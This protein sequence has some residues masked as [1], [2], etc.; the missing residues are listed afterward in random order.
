MRKSEGPAVIE[1]LRMNINQFERAVERKDETTAKRC[2]DAAEMM[3][4]G[5]RDVASGNGCDV[6]PSVWR[7]DQAPAPTPV[8]AAGVPV[9]T[10]TP[11]AL[12]IEAALRKVFAERR[13]EN[14]PPPPDAYTAA[15]SRREWSF[16][17]LG[18]LT[19]LWICCAAV[20][21]WRAVRWTFRGLRGRR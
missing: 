3:F 13:L 14:L 8:I 10:A 5:L 2:V 19:W 20:L 9:P 18:S 21:V 17:M 16:R 12:D 11:T 1:V 6:G 15:L 7:G 4:R